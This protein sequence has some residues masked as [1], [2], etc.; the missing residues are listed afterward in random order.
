MMTF[1]VHAFALPLSRLAVRGFDR[2]AHMAEAAREV[3]AEAEQMAHEARTRA[4][5]A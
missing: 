3:F 1:F 2:L 5:R 4:T